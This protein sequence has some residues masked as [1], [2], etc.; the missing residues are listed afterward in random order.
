MGDASRGDFEG[1][2][3][4]VFEMGDADGQI[5]VED[6]AVPG[7][8]THLPRQ[9]RLLRRRIDYLV[10][11][12]G[13]E[14]LGGTQDLESVARLRA[15]QES[16]RRLS[17]ASAQGRRTIVQGGGD[18][19]DLLIG[20]AHDRQVRL[21]LEHGVA[22]SDTGLELPAVAGRAVVAVGALTDV[23]TPADAEVSRLLVATVVGADDLDIEA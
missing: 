1:V 8:Q 17:E 9:I 6:A 20:Q 4:L 13:V 3:I 14:N 18:A 19:V 22:R 10:R 23:E 11:A 12:V 5:Q 21:R 2:A 15:A 7:R 16:E